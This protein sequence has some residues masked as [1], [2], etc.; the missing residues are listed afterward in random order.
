M[1]RKTLLTESELRRFMKLAD[2]R[3]VGDERIQEMGSYHTPG[4]RDEEDELRHSEEEGEAE[5][6]ELS[7]MDDEADRE[8]AEID[9]LE[10]DLA[11][12]DDELAAEPL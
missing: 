1:A 10:G 9:D 4:L 8:G 7:D 11:M 5:G 6:R 3:P 12:A 2:M